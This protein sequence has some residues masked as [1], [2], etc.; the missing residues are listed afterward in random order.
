MQVGMTGVT[1]PDVRFVMTA[2]GTQGARPASVTVVLGINVTASEKITLFLAV[3]T[4]GN[5]A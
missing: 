3:D 1:I 2:A 5:M 4:R